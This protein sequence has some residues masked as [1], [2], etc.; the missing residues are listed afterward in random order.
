MRLFWQCTLYSWKR[1]FTSGFFFS[2]LFNF[3]KG[4]LTSGFSDSDVFTSVF[5]VN[6]GTKQ[7][8]ICQLLTFILA[9]KNHIFRWHFWVTFL[10]CIWGKQPS[11]AKGNGKSY[12]ETLCDA[13][14]EPLRPVDLLYR[15][16]RLPIFW[17]EIWH[18]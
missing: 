16:G 18:A 4:E 11:V 3:V 14:F 7:P 12:S 9:N 8:K 15:V 5:S 6:I 10:G 17:G 1:A 2:V 13:R